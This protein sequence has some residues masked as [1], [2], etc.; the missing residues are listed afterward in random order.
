MALK[1]IS[2][3]LELVPSHTEVSCTS[4]YYIKF[5][6]GDVHHRIGHCLKLIY[7][8]NHYPSA[9]QYYSLNSLDILAENQPIREPKVFM[10]QARF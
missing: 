8:S 2:T 7:I 3:G 6:I 4:L 10:D 1:L 9:S 5:M